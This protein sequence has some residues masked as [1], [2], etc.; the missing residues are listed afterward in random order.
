MAENKEYLMTQDEYDALR[1]KL[2]Y[3]K[4]EKMREIAD[5]INQARGYGD[6][7]ENAEYDAAKAEQAENAEFIRICEEKIKHAKVVESDAIDKSAVNIGL[8]VKVLDVDFDEEFTYEI[9]GTTG[10]DPLNNKIS[11]DSP[12]AKAL[13]GEKVGATVDVTTPDGDVYQLKILDISKK[14]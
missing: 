11:V 8:M 10:A 2:E 4:N 13:I 9:T 6:L 14:K 5:K 7:S 12:V 1:D 3:L